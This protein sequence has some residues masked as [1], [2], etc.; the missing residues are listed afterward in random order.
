[1]RFIVGFALVAGVMA[2]I[3]RRAPAIPG[4]RRTFRDTVTDL[5]FTALNAILTKPVTRITV[6]LVAGIWAALV[7]GSLEPAELVTAFSS[8]SPIGALPL[9]VQTVVGFL[10]ADFIGYWVHRSFHNG[11]LWHFHAI[12]HAPE[13]LDWLSSPRVHPLN[14]LIGT[15]LRVMPLFLLGFRLEA[16]VLQIPALELY[17]LLIHANVW[18]R[19]GPLRYVITTPGF[20]RWHHAAPETMPERM[21][22]H[23]VNFAG[24]LP[25][26]DL[27][28]GTYHLP[29]HPPSRCGVGEPVPAGFFGQLRW[30]WKR[31][32]SHPAALRS[33]TRH[34]R[35]NPPL[36]QVQ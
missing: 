21:R 17:G 8:R 24:I 14:H 1:M 5:S 15:L 20:H 12:H 3:Q 22:A 10:V 27:L 32:A 34:A 29:D 26:W 13:R 23:G 30:P 6:L 18:W 35:R 36:G 7:A 28:F 9:W 16:L 2:V 4:Q 19:L 25:L 11:R 31:D 33:A